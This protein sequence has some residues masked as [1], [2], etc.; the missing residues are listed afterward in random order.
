MSEITCKICSRTIKQEPNFELNSDFVTNSKSSEDMSITDNPIACDQCKVEIDSVHRL[1][2]QLHLPVVNEKI[3]QEPE[4]NNDSAMLEVIYKQ[5]NPVVYNRCKVE[6]DQHHPPFVKEERDPLDDEKIICDDYVSFTTDI[7]LITE[8][9]IFYCYQ[10]NYGTDNKKHLTDHIFTHRFK[11]NQF[12]THKK[13]QFDVCDQRISCSFECH[14][15]GYQTISKITLKHHVRTH[16]KINS[17]FKSSGTLNEHLNTDERPFSCDNCDYKFFNKRN[18]RK[19]KIIHANEKQFTCNKCDYKAHTI[20]NLQMHKI[21]HSKDKQFNCDKCDYKTYSNYFL[22]KHKSI[23]STDKPFRCGLCDFR[24]KLSCSLKMHMMKHSGE[25]PFSCDKC[26]YKSYTNSNVVRHKFIHSEE[27]HFTCDKCGY[28][29]RTIASLQNH[30][31]IHSKKKRF[32]CDD[33]DYKGHTNANL[34]K[35]KIIHSLEK[36][37]KCS[38]CD[39]CC[40]FSSSLKKHLMKHS[41]ERPL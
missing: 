18:L 32:S 14:D 5:D 3:K 8:E 15:C 20:Y 23:H 17:P 6:I 39:Y 27:K 22:Q 40:N 19:H 9:N 13:S 10:C 35:H 25:R 4:L 26:D 28:K 30:K 16:L 21:I 37:F 34:Q 2:T 38:L 41:D 31:F 12:I 24:C 33:C 11:C 7:P 29:T 36:P 1:C